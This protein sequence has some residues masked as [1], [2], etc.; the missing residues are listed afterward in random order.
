MRTD[1]GLPAIWGTR[2]RRSRFQGTSCTV[3]KQ[4]RI[5][6]TKIVLEEGEAALSL[7]LLTQQ[8]LSFS[9]IGPKFDPLKAVIS[10]VITIVDLVL[11]LC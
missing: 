3:L 9:D 1:A 5:I 11:S 2:K 7:H 6:E 4:A 10:V 8:T